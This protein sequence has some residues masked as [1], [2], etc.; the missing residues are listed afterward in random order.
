MNTTQSPI[1]ALH[2]PQHFSDYGFDSQFDYFQ[3][4]EEARKHKRETC[5]SR[6][7]I[8]NLHFKLQKPVTK[9][10]NSKKIKKSRKR[11]WKHALHFFKRKRTVSPPSSNVVYGDG[12]GVRAVSGPVYLA[13]SRSGNSTPTYHRLS[14]SRPSSGPLAGTITPVRK[15]DLDIPYVSLTEVNV[16]QSYKISASPMPI[17]LVT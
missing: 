13:E 1:F 7:N 14:T 12:G 9:D 2:E 6:S 15:G 10:D 4:L 11:W 16:D 17:Y 5:S 3:V 8:D